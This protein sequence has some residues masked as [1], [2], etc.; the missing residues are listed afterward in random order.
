M[1]TKLNLLPAKVASKGAIKRELNCVAFYGDRTVATDSF[2]ALEVEAGGEKLE[3]PE[4]YQSDMV[5]T[6]KLKN[7][8]T[9]HE[10]EKHGLKNMAD[11]VGVYPDVLQII[12]QAEK[13][14]DYVEIS[15]N[16]RLLGEMLLLMA[17]ANAYEQVKMRVPTGKKLPVY[18]YTD[19]TAK[20]GK[21]ESKKMRGL[22][23]P[24][25]R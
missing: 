24:M 19:Q 25:N 4:L 14:E 3:K 20:R 17:K 15:I 1:Y 18:L 23:M 13:R 6:V 2:R 21:N 5:K 12:D 16:G 22:V 8:E 10:P 7:G 9:M 11:E